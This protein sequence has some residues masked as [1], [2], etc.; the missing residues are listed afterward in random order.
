MKRQLRTLAARD[1][2]DP[3]FRRL[4]YVRYADDTLLG[5]AGPKLEA[6]EIKTRLGI[7]LR[8]TLKLE[9]SQEKTLITHAST[10]P[11]RF[12]GY[13]IIVRFRN[14]RISAR[15]QRDLNGNV[16]LRLPA[17]VVEK[18]R[19]QYKQKGKPL[20]RMTLASQPD[21]TI[22]NTYQAEYRGL[23][24]Y[25]QL[26]DNVCWLSRLHWG[27]QQ[28]LLHTLAAKYRKS[29]QAMVHRYRANIET[30]YGARACLQVIKERKGGKK[31][32]IAPFGGIPLIH[33]KQAVLVDRLP[34]PVRYEQKEV[35]RRLIASKCELCLIKC[36]QA[37]VHHVR[38]LADLERMG[39]K[40]PHGAQIMLKRRRKTLIVCQA[41]HY[42]IHQE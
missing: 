22:L 16:R 34:T 12:L 10:Q 5:F 29:K 3:D 37:V 28:S 23:Y 30:S 6:E 7:F 13:D 40:R 20:R 14:D 32:L 36:E 11:A 31:P 25:Y 26:A 8:D 24:Q 2:H 18:K 9:L 27:M 41:C 39:K 35:L 1:P 21:Y 38:K 33:R 42:L 4:K 17:E 19:A 15:G